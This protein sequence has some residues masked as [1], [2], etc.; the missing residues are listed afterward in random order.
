M[1]TNP[2]IEPMVDWTTLGLKQSTNL[3]YNKDFLFQTNPQPYN[4]TQITRVSNII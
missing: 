4:G 1:T 3:N 2:A